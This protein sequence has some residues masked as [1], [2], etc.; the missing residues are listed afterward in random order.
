MQQTRVPAWY[1]QRYDVTISAVDD[2][3]AQLRSDGLISDLEE[4]GGP[5]SIPDAPPRPSVLGAMKKPPLRAAGLRG[6][7]QYAVGR[8]ARRA[9]LRPQ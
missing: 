3:S 8:R 1:R 5:P 2:G 6:R 4:A 9:P 7:R